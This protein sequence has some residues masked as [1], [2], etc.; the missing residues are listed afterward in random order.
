MQGTMNQDKKHN[1][2]NDTRTHAKALLEL[3]LA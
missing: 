2:K 1:D 3:E